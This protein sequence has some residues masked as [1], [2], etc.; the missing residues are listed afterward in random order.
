MWKLLS[1]GLMA[2]LLFG[3]SAGVSWYLRHLK[4]MKAEQEAAKAGEVETAAT[5]RSGAPLPSPLREPSANPSMPT[6]V[7]APFNAEAESTV[8]LASQLKDRLNSVQ[9]QED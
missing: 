1:V 6:A 7:R 9:A 4:E 3:A 5:K 8:Q 2:V